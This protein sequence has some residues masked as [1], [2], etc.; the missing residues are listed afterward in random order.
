M[1]Y[2]IALLLAL[3][4]VASPAWAGPFN[5]KL[6]VCLVKSTTEADKQLL[7]RWIFAAM[8]SHPGVKD[9]GTVSRAEGDKLNKGVATLFWDLVSVRCG[10]ETRDAIKFEGAGALSSSF[11]V[12]G[13]V[14]MQGLMADPQVTQFIG[15]IDANMDKKAMQD[16]LNGVAA[17]A[18][19]PAPA[20]A[21]APAAAPAK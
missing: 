15:G 20:A 19:A 6:A 13:K 11:E 8:A 10:A 1:K 5:D 17:P 7:M 16:L 18:P 3:A 14:A 2:R 12:L 9:L 21:A 4:S